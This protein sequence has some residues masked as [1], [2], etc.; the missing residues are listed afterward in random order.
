MDPRLERA[1]AHAKDFAQRAEAAIE[2]EGPKLAEQ[3]RPHAHTLA[4]KAKRAL[5]EALR[6]SPPR[7]K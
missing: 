1:F 6:P 4:E 7:P 3:L 2:K 5:S